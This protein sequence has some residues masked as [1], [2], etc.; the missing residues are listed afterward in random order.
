MLRLAD[1]HEV[2]LINSIGMRMPLPGKTSRF[3]HR[4]WRKLKSML[5]FLRTPEPNLPRFHVLS[6]VTLP[7]YGNPWLR[8]INYFAI[9][10]QV[11]VAMWWLGI[12]NPN[13]VVTI[14]TAFE[15]A[16]RLPHNS[17]VY[18]RSDKHS[19]FAEANA[20]YIKSLEKKLLQES[21]CVLYVSRSLMNE[22]RGVARG[23]PVF[24]D[25]GVDL[26]LFTCSVEH[27]DLAEIPHP[28]IGFVGTLRQG[29]VDLEL[30]ERVAREIPE[31][32]L[33][34]VGNADTCPS[35]LLELDNVFSLG[36]R[37]HSEV[38]ALASGLDAALMPW[39]QN[40]W[41]RNCNPIKLKEYL[42]L[43]LSVVS[44]PFAELEHYRDVVLVAD[45]PDD[46][47]AK[48]RIAIGTG[49]MSN[50]EG[51]RAKVLSSSW[52]NKAELLSLLCEST[53]R[54]G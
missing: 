41:I 34:L 27:P 53:K 17:L 15:V 32:S 44:M 9:R 49:G 4:I 19:A 23:Q 21:D 48:V 11:R 29:V 24:L 3:G 6:P 20:E 47:I 16:K 18:N 43:G 42:A 54:A 33:V 25:H 36:S 46:F 35:S 45:D 26:E 31:A 51:R 22:E 28:R 12:E 5:R 13:I 37:P 2:L 10:L 40:D 39:V 38:P 30:L 50:I 1:E 8:R 52:D 14:P 7:F